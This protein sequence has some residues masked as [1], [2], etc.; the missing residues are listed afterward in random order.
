VVLLG[1][2]LGVS[3]GVLIVHL[4]H[5]VTRTSLISARLPLGWAA[6]IL[7]AAAAITLLGSLLPVGSLLPARRAARASLLATTQTD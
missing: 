5:L 4:M 3:C 2:L 7:A 1:T 6:L